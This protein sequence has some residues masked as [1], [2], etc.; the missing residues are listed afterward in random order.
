[1]N[2]FTSTE[3]TMPVRANEKQVTSQP[4]GHI[5]TNVNVWSPD[6][7]RL[8][9][10]IRSD[11]AGSSFDGSRIELVDVE[12][13]E[14]SL[15]YQ[16][17]KGVHCGAATYDPTFFRAVFILGPENPTP[18]YSYNAARREGVFV[19]EI[20]P[21]MAVN[22]DGRDLVPPFTPGCHRGGTH[23]HVWSPDS[24]LVS[25]TYEDDLLSSPRS[26]S[27]GNLRG[28]GVAI[29]GHPAIAPRTHR[30]NVNGTSFSVL[31]SKL[32]DQPTPGSDEICKAF[33][34]AWVGQK[35]YRKADGSQ[36]QYALAFQGHVITP[37][38]E[39]ISEVFLVDLPGD[40]KQA[41]PDGPLCGTETQ[42]PQPPLGT[43]QRRLT[44]T[45]N[46]RY[47]GIQGPRHWL[48]SSPDGC[49]IAFLMRDDGG[50]VQLW[51]VSPLGGDPLQ[52]TH[53]HHDIASAFTWSPNG[54]HIAH[55]MDG[56]VC[57]TDTAT[58]ETR[59]V[60]EKGPA[61]TQPRP[62][63]CVVSPDGRKIAYVRP[64]QSG[65]RFWN[66]IFVCDI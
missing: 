39:A 15:L 36:Q 58:G 40:L 9:Y 3:F 16:S 44:F 22:L 49:R 17:R 29:M 66:Q 61:E 50:I 63:A 7:R 4:H 57:L 21:G 45:T 25:F 53:N 18:E 38:G 51:T 27:E 30:R 64:V 14:V 1:M 24:Q 60:T 43:T 54:K 65:D 37:K 13:L 47:P 10:D 48:R 33:E 46:R 56:S 32:H 23:V 59:R 52:L 28:I 42:R 20:F 35:G 2:S 12:S 6:S 8:I 19:C 41:G 31:L 34:E 62:E 11:A 26:G 5:L 55:V